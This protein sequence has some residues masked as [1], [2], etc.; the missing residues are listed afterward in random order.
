MDPID[1][2]TREGMKVLTLRAVELCRLRLTMS[3]SFEPR[4]GLYVGSTT[5]EFTLSTRAAA[6]S[7]SRILQEAQKEAQRA[8]AEVLCLMLRRSIVNLNR[9]CGREPWDSI[10]VITQTKRRTAIAMLPF[11][12]TDVGLVFEGLQTGECE[13]ESFGAPEVIFRKLGYVVDPGVLDET[14]RGRGPGDLWN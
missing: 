4:F 9:H 8:H 7:L 13:T 1:P 6:S 14:A 11:R 12:V 5:E 10:F 3:G 2:T